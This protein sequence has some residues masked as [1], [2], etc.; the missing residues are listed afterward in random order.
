MY[1]IKILKYHFSELFFFEFSVVMVLGAGR[2]PLV[3]AVLDAVTTN[4]NACQCKIFAV[5]KNSNAVVT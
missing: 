4:S 5:E 3:T 2:G 1:C